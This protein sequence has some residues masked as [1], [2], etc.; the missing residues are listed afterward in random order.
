MISSPVKSPWASPT[1]D[2]LLSPA[3]SF[4]L[5]W[6]ENC[7]PTSSRSHLL[8]YH[9]LIDHDY[10]LRS[11]PLIILIRL[12]DFPWYLSNCHYCRLFHMIPMIF[13]SWRLECDYEYPY[14][15]SSKNSTCG[16]SLYNF[17]Y[18]LQ[19]ASTWLESYWT[20]TSNGRDKIWR[21]LFHKVIK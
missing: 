19:C 5:F 4:S 13:K 17:M 9:F 21:R 18:M 20:S 10:N 6:I 11:S 14:D 1:S 3:S 2:E 7:P 16:Q 15:V 12:F 8:D